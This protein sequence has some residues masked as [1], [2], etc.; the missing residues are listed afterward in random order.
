MSIENLP[1]DTLFIGQNLVHHEELASTNLYARELLSKNNPSEGT[2]VSTR[3]QSAGRGQIGSAWESEPDKNIN[4]SVILYPTFLPVRQQFQLNQAFSLAVREFIAK[5]VEKSVKIKWPNDIYVN[6]NKIS[7]IL[8]Q[9][10][11]KGVNIQSS[12]IG[13]GINVNQTCFLTN[14]PNPT[15]LKLETGWDFNLLQLQQELFKCLEYRYLQLKQKNEVAVHQEYL[16]HLYQ[17]QQI[18]NFQR[19]SGEVFQGKIVGITD[20][21][22]LKIETKIGLETFAIKEVKF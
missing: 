5:N 2:V 21:G 3:Y 13:L 1:L 6:G 10:T 14:P 8:I 11:L 4:L 17:Y 9:N 18:R 15:S 22:K 19:A 7:G 20:A 12:I 16:S